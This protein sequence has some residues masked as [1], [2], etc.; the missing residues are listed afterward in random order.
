MIERV[1]ELHHSLDRDG[2]LLCFTG[3]FTPELI[4]ALLALLERKMDV[5]G[6]DHRVRKR[7][8]NVMLEGLQNLYHHPRTDAAAGEAQPS[9]GAEAVML[10]ARANNGFA[11]ATGNMIETARMAALKAHLDRVNGC[12]A[13]ELRE[14]YQRTLSDGRYGPS[15]GGGLGIID[16]ARKSGGKLEYGFVPMDSERTFFSLNVNVTA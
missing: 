1:F 3:G 15:G 10:V 13:T 8:F 2:V 11:V 12:D 16:M 6:T 5:L 7:V 4:T 9:T 14:L